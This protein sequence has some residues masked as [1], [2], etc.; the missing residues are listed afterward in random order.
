MRLRFL[1][2]LLCLPL[3]ALAQEPAAEPPW[4][5]AGTVIGSVS[6]TV[7]IE[8]PAGMQR[9]LH[10]G[11]ALDDCTIGG[12]AARGLLLDCAGARRWR[13]LQHDSRLLSVSRAMAP[14]VALLPDRVFRELL[15]QPQ[16]LVL[17]VSLNPRVRNGHMDG[18]AVE[19][20]KP[21]GLLE[22][23][24]LM[25]GDVIV[26]VNGSPVSEPQGFMRTLG[27]LAGAPDFLLQLEHD[28]VSRDLQ[29]RL[30]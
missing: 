5:V 18:Y 9:R 21:G 7:I 24:G 20:L 6:P 22:G 25:A 13:G 10:I 15:N 23:H 14:G 19:R 30:R 28:G 29:V 26:A 11:E 8:N 3:K 16:R 17:E 2:V 27:Q 1:P 4:R 12:I